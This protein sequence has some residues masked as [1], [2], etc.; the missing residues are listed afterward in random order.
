MVNKRAKH[1]IQL[2]AST[3]YSFDYE[4]DDDVTMIKVMVVMLA[5]RKFFSKI[6]T[7]KGQAF[8]LWFSPPKKKKK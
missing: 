6:S 7:S 4:V 1:R 3:Y 8:S 5:K 2:M